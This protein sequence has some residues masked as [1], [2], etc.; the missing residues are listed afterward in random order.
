MYSNNICFL[1]SVTLHIFLNIDLLL[2]VDKWFSNGFKFFTQTCL[3]RLWNY[4]GG[5][6]W[7]N[8]QTI[9]N[10]KRK[11]SDDFWKFSL[12]HTTEVHFVVT[13]AGLLSL[14]SG[15]NF[16]PPGIAMLRALAVK[17]L[18]VSNR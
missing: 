7:Q 1:T 13:Y 10:K 9:S 3:E 17:K 8:D 2:L 4:K 16:G 11:R 18:L 14:M 6:L 12:K 5:N 15:S